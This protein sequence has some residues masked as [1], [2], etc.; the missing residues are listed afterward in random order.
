MS[1]PFLNS[2]LPG[3]YDS[4]TMFERPPDSYKPDFHSPQYQQGQSI[5]PLMP[6]PYPSESQRWP[7]PSLDI[8]EQPL[9][10]GQA[11]RPLQ[12]IPPL[13]QGSIPNTGKIWNMPQIIPENQPSLTPQYDNQNQTK[14]P[15]P[16]QNVL[17]N[18]Q[19]QFPYL[20][21]FQ[22]PPFWQPSNYPTNQPTNGDG[23]LNQVH[24]GSQ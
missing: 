7:P 5:P 12:N 23:E 17:Q 19:Q 14:Q 11:G 10:Q 2:R 8:Q 24:A 13:Q 3:V 16:D 18:Q 22:L 20:P 6:N 15:V 9:R 21:N 4:Q 1:P